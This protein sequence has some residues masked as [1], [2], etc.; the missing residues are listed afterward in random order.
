MAPV[1][2]SG[3]G[4]LSANAS[5]LKKAAIRPI[6]LE[7]KLR[8]QPVELLGQHRVAEAVDRWANSA[9]IEASMVV[10]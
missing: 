6:S 5:G 3:V 2:S 7:L 4:P 1:A 9:T 10:S 8:I